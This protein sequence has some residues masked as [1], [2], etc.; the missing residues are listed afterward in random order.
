MGEVSVRITPRSSAQK[1]VH[2]GGLLRAWVHAAPTEGEANA[3]LLE[4]M[5]STLGIPKSRLGLKRGAK[6]R[7][8]I[9]EVSGITQ[10]KLEKIIKERIG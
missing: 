3:A 5:A 6:S 8:K 10:E 7:D 4:L 2:E 1:L 9:V